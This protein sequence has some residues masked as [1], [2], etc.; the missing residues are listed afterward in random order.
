M[1][2]ATASLS[3][4]T[5][6]SIAAAVPD[7]VLASAAPGAVA[8]PPGDFAMALTDLIAAAPAPS[9]RQN[10][11]A[12][13]KPVPDLPVAL[14]V[15]ATEATDRHEALLAP[16]SVPGASATAEDATPT[17]PVVELPEARL[18]PALAWLM[19]PVAPPSPP[20]AIG[21][22]LPRVKI[23]TEE[24]APESAIAQAAPDAVTPT[25]P[26]SRRGVKTAPATVA[27]AR[28][29]IQEPTPFAIFAATAVPPPVSVPTPAIS[30]ASP[31]VPARV[32]SFRGVS[33]ALPTLT[34]PTDPATGPT[35]VFTRPAA[36]TNRSGFATPPPVSS[37]VAALPSVAVRAPGA[38]P[39]VRTPAP[40]PA[41]P[42]IIT[43]ASFPARDAAP[44]IAP[45]SAAV[46][47]RPAATSASVL[48]VAV[49]P[50]AIAPATNAPPQAPVV[51]VPVSPAVA[52]PPPPAAA[53]VDRPVAATQLAATA[54]AAPV[55]SSAAPGVR[56]G[57]PLPTAAAA[58]PPVAPRTAPDPRVVATARPAAAGPELA[59]AVRRR[60]T[61]TDTPAAPIAAPA[62]GGL[63]PPVAVAASSGPQPAG[64]DLTRDPGLHRMIDHIER[65]REA[66]PDG[67]ARET[68]IRLIPDA[69]GPVD[70]A[71]KRDGDAVQVHF[72]AAESATRTL[73]VD[74]Q[75]RLTE[76]AEARGVRIDRATVDAG[77]SERH[78]GAQPQP[79]QQQQQPAR[80][81]AATRIIIDETSDD[82]VA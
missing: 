76:L 43:L 29:A 11:A 37:A 27:D 63:Q 8:V 34:V 7:G 6:S 40:I 5:I 59:P 26:L 47:L 3:L 53:V 82:R 60:V 52:V 28:P 65:L 45:T 35:T 71:V 2:E 21:V 77:A 79:Q 51:P 73:I 20:P 61:D 32:A 69:L 10:A 39:T 9:V 33:P 24:P 48:A 58:P 19:P 81:P 22:A 14:P 67:G 46:G 50:P 42:T 36:K 15:P 13:G 75:P 41:S 68:R 78:S 66:A 55:P 56:A 16:S 18:E 54:T 23:A 31:P 62:G 80:A 74:A 72:T 1:I 64:I 25:T 30:G 4:L 12:P 17:R 38:L 49:A 70:I 44:P 57:D